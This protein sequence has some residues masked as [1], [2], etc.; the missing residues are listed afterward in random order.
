MS[1]NAYL[2]GAMRYA[3]VETLR[4]ELALKSLYWGRMPTSIG[5]GIHTSLYSGGSRNINLPGGASIM[6]GQYGAALFDLHIMAITES[7]P[8]SEQMSVAIQRVIR[9]YERFFFGGGHY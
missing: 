8:L 1:E 5:G 4:T 3:M 2:Q 9:N 6:I 7:Q